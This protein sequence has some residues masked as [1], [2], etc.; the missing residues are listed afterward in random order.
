MNTS[1]ITY[2]LADS[3]AILKFNR[4]DDRNSLSNQILDILDDTL[5]NIISDKQVEGIVFTGTKD[6]FLSGANIRE[7]TSLDQKTAYAFSLKGQRLMQRVAEAKP[8]TVAAINGYCMG[9]G[10]DFALACDI[11]VANAAAVFAHPGARLGIITG[12]GGTQRLSRLI[13]K[14]RALEM[15]ST[16]RRVSSSEAERIGLITGIYEPVLEGALSLARSIVSS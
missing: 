15:F 12:W 4:P 10:L 7:L 13:G 11:R 16:A 2:E 3:I 6:V 9:G 8:V 1:P 5:S 14:S